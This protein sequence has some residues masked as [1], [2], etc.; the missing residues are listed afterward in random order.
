METTTTASGSLLLA[1]LVALPLLG[2]LL[3][4]F[5][6]KEQ[7]TAHRAIGTV[8]ASLVFLLSIPLVTGFDPNNPGFQFAFDAAWIDSVG[9]TASI[10]VDG[11]SLW[12]IMLTTFLTPLI[13]I[14]AYQA[15][16]KRVREFV[17][18]MLVLESA[19]IGALVARD[20]LL[21][22]LFW[23][24]MLV[25]MYLL[26]GIWGGKDRLYATIKFVIYTIVGSL[27]MLVG[28]VYLYIQTGEQGGAATF[29]Y[30]AIVALDLTET[31]QLW[32]FAAFG[33]AFL[34]KVPLFPF[35]TWLPDAHTQ[36]PTAGSVVLA[37]VLLKMGTYGLLRFALPLFPEAMGAF[38]PAIL[39]LSV[40][41]IVYGALV[42]FAQG[43]VKKLVAYS[44]VS[45][46]GFVMLGIVALN[47]Q[48]V[49]GSILQMINHGISTGALFMLVGIIYERRHTRRI[50]DFGGIGAVM[51]V[52][53]VLFLIVT[54]SSIGLPG[55]NGFAGEFLILSGAFL[56][57]L[58]VLPGT[59]IGD[60]PMLAAIMAVVATTGVVLGAIYMLSMVRR[61]FFGPLTHE[62]NKELKDM[63]MR[64]RITLAP[65][66]AGIFVI[67]LFPTLL[68]SY[69]TASVAKLVGEVRPRVQLVRNT[70]AM[71][72]AADREAE[73]DLI[74]VAAPRAASV[75]E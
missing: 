29:A 38:S 41:G 37:G 44:S 5:I 7:Q 31:E 2:A 4:A 10:G 67:G 23:E 34:I 12:I 50:K 58:P 48:S 25:P 70:R 20:L 71:R 56:D 32:L 28:V 30:D 8:I 62:E 72:D 59:G 52:F 15:V 57:A 9:A 27:L 33:L 66:I 73:D 47:Q 64:E 54:M 16:D 18:A 39:I 22:Y 1:A 53:T 40:I 19:M 35:H 11:I 61:V 14:G 45:H 60:W 49:E 24:M 6:P 65:M 17:I 26:I 69:T 63:T 68:T 3:L 55:T 51:P 75:E 13:L 46:L 43:D 42:A 21:F 36:A 74:R